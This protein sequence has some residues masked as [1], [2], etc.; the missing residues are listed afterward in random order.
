MLWR[1]A[2]IRSNIFF[3]ILYGGPLILDCFPLR[4]LPIASEDV[5]NLWASNYANITVGIPAREMGR[6]VGR[7]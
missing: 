4:L 5:L 7:C 2:Y 6:Y 1:L 3:R